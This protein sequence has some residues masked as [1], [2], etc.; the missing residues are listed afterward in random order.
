MDPVSRSQLYHQHYNKFYREARELSEEGDVEGLNE[1][2]ELEEAL[3][4]I[5]PLLYRYTVLYGKRAGSRGSGELLECN[6]A[7]QQLEY[8]VYTDA[9]IRPSNLRAA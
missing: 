9:S 1:L 4:K 2:S 3:Q 8:Q 6:E 5:P 7:L